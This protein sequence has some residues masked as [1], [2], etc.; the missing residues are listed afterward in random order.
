MDR[1]LERLGEG[2]AL[3]LK[4]PEDKIAHY[5]LASNPDISRNPSRDAL[6]QVSHGDLATLER[7]FASYLQHAVDTTGDYRAQARKLISDILFDEL[8]SKDDF[9]VG[10]SV[11]SFNY[12]RPIDKL[13]LN[14]GDPDHES[15]VSFVNIHGRLGKD[16]II[17][18]IDGTG[19][20]D[21]ADILPFTKTYRI[22]ALD[23]PDTGSLIDAPASGMSND[24]G[25]AMIKFYGHSL[26]PAD[27][28]YFQAIFDSVHLYESDTRVIFYYRPYGGMSS[29]DVRTAT[30]RKVIHLLSAYSKTLDNKDHGNNLIH[31]LILEGRL[32]VKELPQTATT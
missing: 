23:V 20:T 21:D 10:S 24:S 7:D 29:R 13:I 4:N 1:C 22:M 3:N 16:D 32:S 11:L 19:H 2:T 30:M 8:P 18:G 14:P 17:F 28:A 31:K 26:G 9:D 15:K 5:L 25:T 27:Y 6:L 12:T